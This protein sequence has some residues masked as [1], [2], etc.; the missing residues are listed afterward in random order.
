MKWNQDT[1]VNCARFKQNWRRKGC[2]AMFTYNRGCLALVKEE[3]GAAYLVTAL[4]VRDSS[5]M[6]VRRSR[7]AVPTT[8]VTTSVVTQFKGEAEK[9]KKSLTLL[10]APEL[11]LAL[12][13]DRG[14][15][16]VLKDQHLQP[17]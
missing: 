7:Q 9:E 11:P 3:F 13:S 14:F 12:G 16:D 4:C 2:T 15:Q 8:S 5:F 10:S 6:K 17:G 1:A